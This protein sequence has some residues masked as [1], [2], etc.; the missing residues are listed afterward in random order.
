MNPN[1]KYIGHRGTRVGFD[2]NTNSAFETVIKYGANYIEFD[3]QKT[4]D[5]KL[6]ILHDYSL[7][8]TTNG[9]GLLREYSYQEIKTFRTKKK[10]EQIPNLEDLLDILK[11][12]TKF[13]IE[14]KGENV[15][16]EVLSLVNKKDLINDCVFSGRNLGDLLLIKLNY[17]ECKICYNITKGRD[18]TLEKFMNLGK[19]KKLTEK[20]D[21]IS[22]KSNL[23]T[24][25]F[26]D[27]CHNNNI[28]TLSWDFINYKNA[29]DKIKSL[30]NIGIDGILFDNY[31]N[32]PIIKRWVEKD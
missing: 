12:K 2:E 10:R 19:K 11:G 20:P 27:I 28:L 25:Q 31:K 24:S 9:S 22:L 8:R 13:I 4:K 15:K 3:V 1:F 26:I 29:L 30:V 21:L 18:I 32:I 17:P 6:I 16:N 7:E 14:L 5:G 23:V